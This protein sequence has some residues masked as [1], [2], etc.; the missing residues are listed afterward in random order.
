M[1][2]RPGYDAIQIQISRSRPRRTVVRLCVH[3]ASG[4]YARRQGL[5]EPRLYHMYF[6]KKQGTLD[7]IGRLPQTPGALPPI[8]RE[9]RGHRH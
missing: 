2:E 8:W 9:I 1:C 6:G 7:Y 4:K 3:Y 5:V